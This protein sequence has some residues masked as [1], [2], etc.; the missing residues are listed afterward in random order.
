MYSSV[1]F[2]PES[3]INPGR[4]VHLPVNLGNS[5]LTLSD[6]LVLYFCLAYFHPSDF[7]AFLVIF[8]VSAVSAVPMDPV[9][10]YT[11]SS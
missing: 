5:N 9:G 6:L 1:W 7:D 3:Y 10:F 2:G 11:I 4:P 8:A